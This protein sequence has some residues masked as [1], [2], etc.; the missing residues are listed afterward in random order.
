[1][2]ESQFCNSFT[3]ITIL[4]KARCIK[5]LSSPPTLFFNHNKYANRY[6]FSLLMLEIP[7]I[8]SRKVKKK[9]GAE[10]WNIETEYPGSSQVFVWHSRSVIVQKS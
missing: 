6:S 2:L 3:R 4:S 8:I 5:S 9:G 10:W 1:M 7:F